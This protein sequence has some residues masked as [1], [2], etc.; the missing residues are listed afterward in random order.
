MNTE[1]VTPSSW[2]SV[3]I[4]RSRTTNLHSV[5]S[6]HSTVMST[7]AAGEKDR[8]LEWHGVTRP[9]SRHGT[10]MSTHCVVLSRALTVHGMICH[11]D[12][13][14]LTTARAEQVLKVVNASSN[15]LVANHA[16][17]DQYGEFD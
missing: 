3:V 6:H 5:I 13:T 15:L 1:Y 9:I 4:V 10:V 17:V 16:A 14:S 12:L 8:R 11:C 7:H 2:S